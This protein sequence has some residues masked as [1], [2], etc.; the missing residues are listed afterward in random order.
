[1][2]NTLRPYIGKF[3]IIYLDNIVIFFKTEDKYKEYLR[4]VL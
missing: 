1:M 3:I 2:N 4:K